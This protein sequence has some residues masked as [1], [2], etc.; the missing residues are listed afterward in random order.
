MLPEYNCTNGFKIFII[1]LGAPKITTKSSAIKGVL[2]EP[3]TLR[4]T[5]EGSPPDTFTL[6]KD[7]KQIQ[8][9]ITTSTVT[10]NSTSV[11]VR[12]ECNI[13]NF[14]ASDIG[15]YTFTVTNPLG[16]SSVYIDAFD[17]LFSKLID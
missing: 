11:L 10:H 14:S 5:S 6:E 17:P 2:G 9:S 8:N 15:R 7:G 1:F 4:C 3:L 16:S 13:K 12:V